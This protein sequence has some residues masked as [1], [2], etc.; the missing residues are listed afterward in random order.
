MLY[1]KSTIILLHVHSNN[2]LINNKYNVHKKKKNVF[3][4]SA[5]SRST[6]FLLEYI[7]CEGIHNGTLRGGGDYSEFPRR[8][9]LGA[10]KRLH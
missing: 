7:C 5:F 4:F 3:I 6:N 8:Q 10:E 2:E 9:I 1:R